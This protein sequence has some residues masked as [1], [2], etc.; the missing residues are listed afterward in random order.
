MQIVIAS[1]HTESYCFFL[2]PEGGL[3]WVNIE[4]DPMA[5]PS[6]YTQAGL[7]SGDGR[8]YLL[9]GSGS[10]QVLNYPK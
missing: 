7:V 3:N 10:E 8:F 6:A 1:N 2:Y 9:P 5:H 4:A